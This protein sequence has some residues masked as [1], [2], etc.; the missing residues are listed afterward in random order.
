M[1]GAWRLQTGALLR[2]RSRQYA[3]ILALLASLHPI[4]FRSPVT[5]PSSWTGPSAQREHDERLVVEPADAARS[6]VL[7]V[8]VEA[9]NRRAGGS[10]VDPRCV[11]CDSGCAV[12]AE[13]C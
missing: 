2:P 12:V 1:R 5:A 13:T 6:G 3:R 10:R 11:G 7:A 8:G 9:G 4:G